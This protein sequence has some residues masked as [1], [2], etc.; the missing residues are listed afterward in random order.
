MSGESS[1]RQTPQPAP[2]NPHNKE[3]QAAFAKQVAQAIS[4]DENSNVNNMDL[5]RGGGGGGGSISQTSGGSSS[6]GGGGGVGGGLHHHHH[7]ESVPANHIIDQTVYVT[8][9]AVQNSNRDL[10][11]VVQSSTLQV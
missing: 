5:L 6:S 3:V 1:A 9:Q 11:N 7:H 4:N 8:P 10:D 2:P